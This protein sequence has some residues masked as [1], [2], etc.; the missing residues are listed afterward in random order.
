MQWKKPEA[1]TEPPDP[2]HF[3]EIFTNLSD[4][5]CV[6]QQQEVLCYKSQVSKRLHNKEKALCVGSAFAL[7][8]RSCFSQ[9]PC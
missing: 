6:I 7:Q 9:Q 8:F 3:N 5:S 2:L 1:D 4:V